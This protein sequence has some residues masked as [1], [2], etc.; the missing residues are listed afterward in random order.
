ML[1]GPT[2][3]QAAESR[4]GVTVHRRQLKLLK[5]VIDFHARIGESDL[6]TTYFGCTDYLHRLGVAFGD[7]SDS[8]WSD[9]VGLLIRRATGQDPP[10]VTRT[11]MMVT[12]PED[13]VLYKALLE[14]DLCQCLR[15]MMCKSLYGC[16]NKCLRFWCIY[17]IN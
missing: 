7:F 11:P 13:L 6:Q 2:S 1:I 4:G 17:Y 12:F 9:F 14:T 3:A 15:N 10:R 16:D 5:L 8:V